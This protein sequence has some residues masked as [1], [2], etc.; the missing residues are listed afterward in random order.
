M[1]HTYMSSF[2]HITWST[3]GRIRFFSKRGKWRL[4]GY[5]KKLARQKNAEIIE[6]GGTEDHVH[7]LVRLHSTADVSALMRHIKAVSSGFIKRVGG[8]QCQSFAWQIGY[9]YFSAGSK[10]INGIRHY[11]RNQEKH[12]KRMTFEE[13]IE[14]LKKENN[15]K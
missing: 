6:I 8:D 2:A 11:I 3:K 12:H 14:I 15:K 5:L 10:D 9:G 4:Y 1:S 7:I 13:E